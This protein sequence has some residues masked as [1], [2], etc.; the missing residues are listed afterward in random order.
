[1]SIFSTLRQDAVDFLEPYKA[2]DPATYAAAEQAIGALLITDGFVGISNPLARKKRPGIFG[3]IGG[4]IIGIIFMFIPT[5]VGNVTDLNHMTA[6]T[7]AT[8]AAVGPASYSASGTNHTQT[9]SCPLTVS[10]SVN[11]QTYSSQSSFSSSG[12]CSL[13][14][15]QTITINYDPASPN[16]WIYGAQTI[17]LFVQIFFWAGLLVLISSIITFFIRLFSIIFGWKLL[18]DGRKNAASLPAGTN[19]Q[20][21]IDEVKKDFTASIFG[22]GTGP[23]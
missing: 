19:L 14:T 11:G 15:G 13:S 5:I 9:A 21:M 10:Y 7:S 22:F 17:G 12:Y 6:S 4:I 16:S 1:M 18:K 20:T 2:K 23:Q 8:V 3:A